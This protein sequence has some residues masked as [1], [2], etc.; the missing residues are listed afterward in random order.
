MPLKC[1]LHLL[2]QLQFGARGVR[3]R[4]PKCSCSY[5]VYT[6]ALKYR[7]LG[8]ALG[9]EYIPYTYMDDLGLGIGLEGFQQYA[10][11]QGLQVKPEPHTYGLLFPEFLPIWGASNRV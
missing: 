8:T 7:F 11:A 1:H 3:S 9:P 6:W 4:L 5:M 10:N 2:R